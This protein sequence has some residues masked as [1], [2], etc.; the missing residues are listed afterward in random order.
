MAP[1]KLS[2]ID[3]FL[4][5]VDRLPGPYWLWFALFRCLES[6]L[7]HAIAWMTV[8]YPHFHWNRRHCYFRPGSGRPWPS[9]C[10]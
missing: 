3:R 5:F 4:H 8:R 1:D 7:A 2:Y 10:I 6:G 9:W